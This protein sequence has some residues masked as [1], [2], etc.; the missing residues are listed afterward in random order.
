MKISMSFTPFEMSVKEIFLGDRRYKIPNFQRDFSWENENFVDFYEDLF[1]SSEL[2]LN[3]TIAKSENK[4]FFGMILLLGDK[5]TPN[6]E[7]PYE[8]IDGQQR[9]TT[10]ILF[11]VAIQDIINEKSKE[12]K[13]EFEDRLFCKGTKQGK[14]RQIQRLVNESLDPVLPVS[15]LNLNNMKKDNAE[16]NPIS[17]EQT[18][19]LSAYDYIKELLSKDNLSNSLSIEV[20]K[21]SDKLYLDILDGLGNHL[22]NS[23]LICIFHDNKEEANNLFRN[24]NF[25]GKPLSQSDL[26][27]NEIFS[28]LE[29]S[30]KYASFKWENI[31][32]NIY[33]SGESLQKYIYHYMYGRYTKITNN[34]MF[35]RFNDN[36]RHDR[37][38]YIEFLNS[39]DT[40]SS[41]YKTI[42]KPE[43]NENLFGKNNYFII[44]DNVSIKRNLEFFKKIEISQ[45]RILLITL[46]EFREKEIISNSTFKKYIDLIAK[47][48][49][50]H[51]LVKSSPNKLTSIY[52]KASRAFISDLRKSEELKEEIK[53]LK[54]EVKELKEETKEPNQ[55][56][57]EQDGEN[58][59]LK[60]E[61][62]KLKE[63]I[64]QLIQKV[65][66]IDGAIEE[67]KEKSKKLLEKS[68]VLNKKI[69][70]YINNY[71]NKRSN[72]YD[73]LKNNLLDKLPDCSLVKEAKLTYSGKK[74]G[75]MNPKERKEHALIRFI[76][77]KL[78]E[79]EQDK[80]TNRG[81]DGLGF[82]YKSTL[83]HVVDRREEVENVFSLGN[84]VLLERD[85]HKDVNSLEEKKEMY[86]KSKITKT[87]NFFDEYPNF[88]EK[89]ILERQRTLLELFFNLVKE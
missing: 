23:T 10:M 73:V 53:K 1:R 34:N 74:I 7:S 28:I 25:R 67:L 59:E 70:N 55:N 46:F 27:K 87:I 71:I 63:E 54:E 79:D 32:K 45:C 49:C 40:A 69:D 29:D 66:Q 11:F 22:S 37:K 86:K 16:V 17:Y 2:T 13:T 62:K 57:K 12:Y 88:S 5:S 82:I 41:Y 19:L 26:L 44:D 47:H 42:L 30:S 61:N 68:E 43:D 15:I 52:A 51:V 33:E 85:V 24:L 84:I 76:L 39:L 81:N 56:I 8:V 21:L 9:L 6:E 36:I 83:E 4:Y 64:E 75:E 3:N 58:K 78:S 50:L 18:W 65:N 48:Q 60:E 38:S 35:E 80:K 89:Q 20:T 72:I 77:Q 14:H 31:E